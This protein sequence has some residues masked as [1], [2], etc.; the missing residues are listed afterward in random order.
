MMKMLMNYSHYTE[1]DLPQLPAWT[2]QALAQRPTL[3]LSTAAQEELE[4]RWHLYESLTSDDAREELVQS[5]TRRILSRA[6][7]SR[8]T[9]STKNRAPASLFSSGSVRRDVTQ[10]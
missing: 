6:P 4:A 7:F 10:P 8:E 9:I 3:R 2:L 5:F 1:T